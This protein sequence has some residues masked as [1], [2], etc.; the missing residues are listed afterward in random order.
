M[1]FMYVSIILFVICIFLI[2]I[3]I[4]QKCPECICNE[5]PVIMDNSE[6]HGRG[7]FARRLIKKGEIIEKCPLIIFNRNRVAVLSII[8]DYDISTPDGKHAIMLGYGSIYNHSDD[9]NSSWD[10]NEIPEIVVTAKRDIEKGEE[11]CVSY[12]LRYWEHRADKNIST[13]INEGSSDRE[14]RD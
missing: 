5:L 7:M 14:S 13:G 4:L 6:I 2:V 12:G 1:K 10:F 11:V 3:I 8:R 9:N